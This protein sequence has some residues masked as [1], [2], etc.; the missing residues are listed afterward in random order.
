M[1]IE[2]VWANVQNTLAC[3]YIAPM[4]IED[5]WVSLQDNKII[6]C[7]KLVWLHWLKI[8]WEDI[9]S[10]SHMP[11]PP[12]NYSSPLSTWLSIQYSTSLSPTKTTLSG[13]GYGFCCLS[14]LV[15]G[16]NIASTTILPIFFVVCH[17]KHSD[18]LFDCFIYCFMLCQ[19]IKK[20]ASSCIILISNVQGLS[21][22]LSNL[23]MALHQYDIL[24]CSE[25]LVRYA[26]SVGVV[27]YWNGHPVL[28]C[29][30]T[31][32]GFRD[33]YIC[34]RWIQSILPTQIWVWLLQNAGF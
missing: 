34:K 27:G 18:S 23:I 21:R 2:D 25:T 10:Y 17:R 30:E 5:V 33:C 3:K 13:Q 6:N 11:D 16:R 32:W 26:S 8:L 14:K 24:L 4:G 19:S 29:W 7:H 22:N 9:L 20:R 15:C 1:G 12:I 28:L 31:P